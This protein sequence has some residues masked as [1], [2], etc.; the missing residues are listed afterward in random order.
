MLHEVLSSVAS[1]GFELNFLVVV[2]SRNIGH[3][4]TCARTLIDIYLFLCSIPAVVAL[5]SFSIM[6]A[7]AVVLEVLHLL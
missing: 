6:H 3:A 2:T 1:T 4:C 7:V 5:T